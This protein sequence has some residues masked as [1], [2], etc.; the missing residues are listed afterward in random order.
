MYRKNPNKFKKIENWNE[1]FSNLEINIETSFK[2]TSTGSLL[3]SIGV[4]N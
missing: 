3:E 2:L 4:K 1:Y